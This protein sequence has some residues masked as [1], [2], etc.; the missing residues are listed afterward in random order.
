MFP[1]VTWKS[2]PLA[3]EANLYTAVTEEAPKKLSK[4]QQPNLNA[5]R[6]N[7]QTPPPH[8]KKKK[9]RRKGK[10][11]LKMTPKRKKHKQKKELNFYGS[12]L[13]SESKLITVPSPS[14]DDAESLHLGLIF[15]TS[16]LEYMK[17][18]LTILQNSLQFKERKR[19]LNFRFQW[20]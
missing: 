4:R 16:S 19:D 5:P 7:T 2:L 8:H 11:L 14:K 17:I 1:S 15:F 20:G 10:Q 12:V 6:P 9:N 13:N 3:S 18:F